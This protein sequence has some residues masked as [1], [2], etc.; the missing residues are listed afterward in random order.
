MEMTAALSGV[1]QVGVKVWHLRWLMFRRQWRSWRCRT[2]C[3]R[4]FAVALN[5]AWRG[6]K[7]PAGA[8]FAAI[9]CFRC[10][11]KCAERSGF[12]GLSGCRVVGFGSSML[13]TVTGWP[14]SSKPWDS[15]CV[16]HLKPALLCTFNIVS[17]NQ[18]RT[19]DN[20]CCDNRLYLWFVI[21][22]KICWKRSINFLL[23][24]WI[25]QTILKI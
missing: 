16:W 13:I 22:K 14:Q 4:R 10:L 23:P 25:L 3:S 5:G 2:L 9:T 8:R 7:S 21:T 17:G 19:S 6:G 20:C 15:S 1:Q 12:S 24:L 11:D 18:R